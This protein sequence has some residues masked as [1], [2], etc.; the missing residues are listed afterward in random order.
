MTTPE[1]D[2]GEVKNLIP[3]AIGRPGQRRFCLV[4]EGSDHLA[5][6][7]MEKEQLQELSLSI[8]R[9][10][11]P[12]PMSRSNTYAQQFGF[13]SAIIDT[14]FRV[15]VTTLRVDEEAG[16]FF[17]EI[18]ERGASSTHPIISFSGSSSMVQEMALTA[19][20][21][22]AAG[23]PLCP[24]CHIPLD[25]EVRHVCPLSNGHHVV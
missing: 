3:Q 14:E 6:G 12:G 24:V 11:G 4:I 10:L 22:C 13:D 21:I 25:S 18:H 19:L 23:R 9:K 2:L 16:L 7:W 15:G 8:L 5:V 1:N 17:V 20:E